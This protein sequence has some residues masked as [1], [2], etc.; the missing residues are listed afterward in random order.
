MVTLCVLLWA[1]DGAVQALVEYEDEVLALRPDHG[2]RV[3]KRART[4]DDAD[5][6]TEVHL[7]QFPSEDALAAYLDDDRRPALTEA[8]EQAIERT[9]LYRVKLI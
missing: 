4:L 9:E 2:G 3:V 1:K 7:L 6:P 8:R 5:A